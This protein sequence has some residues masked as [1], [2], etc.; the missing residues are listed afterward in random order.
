LPLVVIGSGPELE[1]L[2]QLAQPNVQ[3]LGWQ[4]DAVV[5]S[6]MSQAKAFV[7]GAYEDFG[8]APV[9]A[10]ACGTPVIAY[11]CGG[12]LET[13][14]DFQTYGDRATGV[15]F[16]TQTVAAIVAA[17]TEFAAHA[18]QIQPEVVRTHA[19]SFDR[20]IFQ[21]QYQTFV[22]QS[23]EGFRRQRRGSH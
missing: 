23:Y 1:T 7:Y 5:E 20:R 3:I 6:H 19:A 18:D 9:E 16:P 15:L 11:G 12:T 22:E 14:R 21:Q 17:V 10:Q 13:V 8:I 2:R 4:S